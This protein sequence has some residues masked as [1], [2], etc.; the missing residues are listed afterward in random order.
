MA[1]TVTGGPLMELGAKAYAEKVSELTEGRVEIEVFPAGTLGKALD[2]SSSVRRGIADVGHTW[3]GYDWGRDKT[4][5][6]FGGFAGSMDSERMLHWLYEGGGQELWTEFRAERF[7]VVSYP[8]FMRPA[9]V[10][11]HSNRPVSTLEDLKGLKLRTAGAWLDLSSKLG[12][13][14]VTM[15]AGDVYTSLER[16]AIDATEWGTLYENVAPGFYQIAK[17][18][19]VPGVHQPSA[20]YELVINTDSFA[21]LSEQDQALVKLAAK[22][23][24]MESWLKL[25]H[26]DAKALEFYRENGNEIIVL[27]DEV[28]RKVKEIAM[29]WGEEQAEGND[30]FSRVFEAQRAYEMLWKDA[31]SYREVALPEQAPADG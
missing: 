18:I 30:W 11:L 31:E 24:T 23:V 2:V 1:T 8:L 17:Y 25:G 22:I 13:A 28:K 4:A 7:G 10:F 19:V 5:V 3:M 15:A 27:E 9:E 16:G 21:K 14:P 6:L 12:A 26:E 20:P 29:E